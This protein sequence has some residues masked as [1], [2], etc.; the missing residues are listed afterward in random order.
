MNPEEAFPRDRKPHDPT[1]DE[2]DNCDRT[3]AVL[4]M[5]SEEIDPQRITDALGI[6]PTRSI[7]K[8]AHIPIRDTDRYWIGRVNAWLLSSE[9]YVTST[10]LNRHLDWLIKTINGNADAFTKLQ[11]W[12]GLEIFVGCVWWSKYG[13]GGPTLG[14]KQ[15]MGLATLNLECSFDLQHYSDER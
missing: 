6:Q 4:R 13:G 12:P 1:N 15:M 5:Y 14:P 10:N 7:T 11:S 8:G 9:P 2:D 3:A